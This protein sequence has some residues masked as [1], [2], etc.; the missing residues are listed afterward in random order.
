[1][2]VSTQVPCGTRCHD[3]L[4]TQCCADGNILDQDEC[5]AGYVGF[6]GAVNCCADESIVGWDECCIGEV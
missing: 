4:T 5:C 6:N 1:M 3:P 2:L